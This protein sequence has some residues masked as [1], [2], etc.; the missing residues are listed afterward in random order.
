M[1]QERHGHPVILSGG[2]S[3]C[4]VGMVRPGRASCGSSGE[5]GQE[6]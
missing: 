3:C 1:P 5:C 2:A 4:I 6:G